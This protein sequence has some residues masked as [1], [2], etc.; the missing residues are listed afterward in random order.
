MLERLSLLQ[1]LLP[2]SLH[3]PLAQPPTHLPLLVLHLVLLVVEHTPLVL[4][5]FLLSVEHTLQQL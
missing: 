3:L 5:L 1:L 2:A 4:H